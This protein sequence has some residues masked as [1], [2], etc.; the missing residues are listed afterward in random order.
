MTRSEPIAIVGL[1]G[2]FPSSRTL[3]DFWSHVASGRDTAK[4]TPPDRW[5]FA[6]ERALDPRRPAPDRVY[7]TRACLVDDPGLL[8]GSLIDGLDIDADFAAK[9]DVMV[10]LALRAGRDAWFDAHMDRVD[11]SRTG[12]ILGNIALPTE[13]TSLMADWVLGRRFDRKLFATRDSAPAAINRFVT[14]LPAGILAKALGLG[15]GHYTLDAAC[16]SSL[17][18]L[19]L[20]AVELR[21]GRADA[22]LTGGLSRP[23]CLYTQMGFAQLTALSPTG[24]CSPFDQKGDGLVVG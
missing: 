1:G 21:A 3:S 16:A 20:A 15:G 23:D 14:G 10:Q 18:A 12:V 24:R 2:V 8:N 11:R 13:S 7:S 22:M 9:L 4:D 19:D 17:F 5:S 6:P